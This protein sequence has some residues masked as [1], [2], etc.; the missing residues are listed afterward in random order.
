MHKRL[1]CGIGNRGALLATGC[2]TFHHVH[3]SR[4]AG[5]GLAAAAAV[6]CLHMPGGAR[7]AYEGG[8]AYRLE[9]WQHRL[10]V[11]SKWSGK[12]G[13]PTPLPSGGR[14]GTRLAD[15]RMHPQS[16][17]ATHCGADAAYSPTSTDPHAARRSARPQGRCP[18]SSCPPAEQELAPCT[19]GARSS[20]KHACLRHAACRARVVWLRRLAAETTRLAAA[21]AACAAATPA[22]ANA[23]APASTTGIAAGVV[24][25]ATAA[26][27]CAPAVTTGIAAGVVCAATAASACAPAVTNGSAAGVVYAAAATSACAPA[28]TTSTAA[29]V[30]GATAIPLD[31]WQ[32]VAMCAAAAAAAAQTPS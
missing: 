19:H 17:Q 28:A 14:K 23:C 9:Q 8:Y 2:G 29:G 18:R 4:L 11:E 25:A 32:H 7:P 5:Q 27:A 3:R 1:G 12:E 22:A 30:V 6:E 13:L 24:C 16:I 31:K 21:L 10:Q 26:S 15:V 20:P